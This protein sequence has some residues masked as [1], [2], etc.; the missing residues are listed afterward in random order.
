[1]GGRNKRTTNS[2]PI[3]ATQIDPVSK[4]TKGWGFSLVVAQFASMPT[5]LVSLLIVKVPK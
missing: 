4:Q 3:W 5:A 2:R 1:L